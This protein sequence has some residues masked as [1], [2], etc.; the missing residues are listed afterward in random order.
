M[1]PRRP[2][3]PARV[4][5]AADLLD[6][7][8]TDRVLEFGCGPGV[9]AALV[10]ER[11]T[12]GSV[13]AI[14]R[15]AT[16]ISRAA[17]RTAAHVD[18]GRV[19][20]AQVALADLETD[21]V[22]DVAFGVNVNLFWTGPAAAECRVLTDVLAPR[23]AVHVIYETPGERADPGRPGRDIPGRVSECLRRHGFEP[24]TARGPDG[25]LVCV[26]GRLPSP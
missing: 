2:D 4:A 8:P 26:S 14:D 13:L 15:S 17:A 21:R 24:T 20:L 5:W 3:I 23:G 16:A 9:A 22:F 25:R 1:A 19:E 12:E 7:A 11:L 10:A 6:L 18:A